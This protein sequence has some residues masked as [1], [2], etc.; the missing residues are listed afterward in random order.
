[1]M[2][3][4]LEA[5]AR[6]L[7]DRT[8]IRVDGRPFFAFGFQLLL[9]PP[10]EMESTLQRIQELGFTAV[11]SPPA[12]PGNFHTIDR[13]FEICNRLGLLVNLV[14]DPRVDKPSEY[15]ANRYKHHPS[16]LSYC[17]P[18]L[19]GSEREFARFCRERDRLRHQDLFHPIWTPYQQDFGL[20]L[21]IDSTDLHA[22]NHAVGSHL[23]LAPE[24]SGVQ[25]ISDLFRECRNHKIPGRPF[26]CHNMQAM[27]TDE[28]RESGVY[29]FD[30]TVNNHSPRHLEWYPYYARIDEEERW[31]FLAPDVEL[32]RLRCF[33]MLASRV[34]GIMVG[35]YDFMLGKAPFTGLD[36]LAELSVLARE[37][38]TIRDF[39]AEGQFVRGDLETGHPGIKA[40]MLHHTDDILVFLWRASKADEFWL[41]PMPMPRVEV[42]LNVSANENVKAWKLDFPEVQPLELIRDAKGAVLVN[43]GAFD[44]T[45]KILLTRSH[46]RPQ[47][48]RASVER[49]LSPAVQSRRT[50][51]EVR[52]Q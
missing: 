22:V 14:A 1:M 15:L 48:I 32:M 42:K 36:R 27:I 41:D 23:S 29:D 34:R 52:Q 37:V 50:M 40:M 39:V 13:I 9:T 45:A 12:S 11:S 43:L 28:V 19:N 49:L 24:E 3:Q 26:F 16:L 10:E 33:E 4:E 31:D 17:L 46:V 47:E 20:R 6:I 2:N 25:R 7:L 30:A 44:L 38:E 21:Y 5:S 18:T 8:T 51:L 35:T